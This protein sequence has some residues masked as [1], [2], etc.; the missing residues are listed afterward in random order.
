MN[1]ALI[2]LLL[3]ITILALWTFDQS[4]I[5]DSEIARVSGTS[6]VIF[7]KADYVSVRVR[8]AVIANPG[9]TAIVT[10]ADGTQKQVASA[11]SSP[12][13][14]NVFLPK[15]GS[16]FGHLGGSTVPGGI[17]LTEQNPFK[18]AI[19]SNTTDSFFATLNSDAFGSI[20]VYWFKIDGK[21]AVTVSS[22]GVGV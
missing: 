6:A 8:I 14:F 2:V 20:T 5:V 16:S 21:A 12:Y 1:K 19:V 22:Y 4:F 7:A 18:A 15:T 17:F 9:T 11:S 10:F 13:Y 3:A